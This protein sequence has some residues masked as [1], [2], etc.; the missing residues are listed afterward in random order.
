MDAGDHHPDQQ[1]GGGEGDRPGRA[2]GLS[3]T[4]WATDIFAWLPSAAPVAA[5]CAFPAPTVV[6][7]SPGATVTMTGALAAAAGFPAPTV[8]TADAAVTMTVAL[9][10]TTSF[11]APA[12]LTPDARAFPAALAATASFPAP[13]V[14]VNAALAGVYLSGSTGTSG[15]GAGFAAGSAQWESWTGL[16]AVPAARYYLA[17][18]TF[19]VQADMTAMIAAGT[20]ICLTLRPR[21]TPSRARTWRP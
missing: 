16:G 6:T 19:G 8:L 17:A 3:E 13:A 5:T 20:K 9:A 2:T 15:G 18:S 4:I 7:S 14:V 11:P 21:T 10:V 12:V 1:R